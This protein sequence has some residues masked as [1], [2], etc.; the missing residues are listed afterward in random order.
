M[1]HGVIHEDVNYNRCGHYIELITRISATE[2]SNRSYA[3]GKQ[4]RHR[5]L[6]SAKGSIFKLHAHICSSVPSIVQV[7]LR[8]KP[9]QQRFIIKNIRVPSHDM[10]DWYSFC[11]EVFIDHTLRNSMKS[12]GPGCNIEIDEATFDKRM[13]NRGRVI[14]GHW[15]FRGIERGTRRSSGKP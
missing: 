13:Y 3:L 8:L 9:L 10:V 15:V 6:I 1:S 2:R 5:Y 12:S 7:L 11:R 4:K 14:E